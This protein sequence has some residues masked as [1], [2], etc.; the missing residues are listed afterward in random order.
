[1]AT[2]YLLRPADE[3][4]R[5][6]ALRPY[7]L[8]TA[9][10]DPLLD[11]VVRLTASLFSTP[12]AIVALVEDTTVHFG[13]NVGL[14]AGTQRERREE[15]VCSVAILQ[16]ETTVYENLPIN[17]CELAEPG[18]ID[19][20]DLQFYAGH[21]LLTADRQPVGVLCVLD[22]HPRQF[23]YEDRALLVRLAELVMQLMD[24]R[25]TS[26]YKPEVGASMWN[27]L[28][29]RVEASVN[30]LGTLAA[31]AQWEENSE[32]EVAVAYRLSTREEIGRVLD[33]LQD[34]IK[35]ALA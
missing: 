28:Y 33:A 7:Q 35:Q 34:M 6:L 30:R 29:D 8:I 25:L 15:S 9:E 22:H 26:T 4:H 1:M 19:R 24:L 10:P 13:L 31:L 16:E 18:L 17:P 5:L 11:E 32:T 20:L 2:S 21:P 27:R 12:I 3:A 23:D 14:P